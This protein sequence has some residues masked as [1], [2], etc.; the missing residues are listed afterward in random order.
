M[1]DERTARM[2]LCALQ[3][4]GNVELGRLV[5]ADGAVEVWEAVRRTGEETRWGRK[6]AAID[7]EQLR[8]AT[9][10]AG[11]RFLVPGDQEWPGSL[12]DLAA[13]S[14]SGD[15][16]AP[17]GLWVRGTLSLKGAEGGIAL[18]GARAAT[19]YGS[20]V[21]TDWAGDLASCGHVIVSGLA[22]GI[23]AAAHRGALMARRPTVAVLA[24]GVDVPY[25]VANSSLMN[26]I[27]ANGAVVSEVPPGSRPIKASFLARNRLIAA[28]CAGLI[29]VEAAA[30]SGAKNTAAWAA[31]LGR[32][33]MAVPG[34]VTSSMSATPNRLI[35]DAAATLVTTPAEVMA[36]L[37]PLTPQDEL[38]LR[39]E[40]TS[41]DRLAPELKL[42][43]EALSPREAVGVAELC[44]RTGLGVSD[45]LA[46][47]DELV[48]GGWLEEAGPQAW[49]LPG[50]PGAEVAS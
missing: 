32:V 49:R 4:M 50:R 15:G 44:A 36:L 16:G 33:V 43:R 21:A 37:Q 42:L 18:V 14:L 25:P 22:F 5:G 10:V 30:R 2:A 39:G 31:E 47:V 41:F 27:L 23:D 26:A 29:V 40:D 9:A 3:P 45:A 17:L 38:P 13:A 1:L 24:S 34:A 7:P 12:Q 28:L 6:A 8:T 11:A 46:G 35:R 20:H 48:E 19:S